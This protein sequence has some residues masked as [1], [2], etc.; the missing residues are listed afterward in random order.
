M[1]DL[2]NKKMVT[3]NMKEDKKDRFNIKFPDSMTETKI[4]WV[5]EYIFKFLE[6]NACE[7]IKASDEN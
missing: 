4:K 7:V 5:K 1:L 3:S 6:R 2:Y